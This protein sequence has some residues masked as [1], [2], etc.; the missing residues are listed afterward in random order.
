M[1]AES[2]TEIA[3]SIVAGVTG[4][5]LIISAPAFSVRGFARIKVCAI[6]TV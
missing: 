5:G 1:Y 6:S 4:I 2:A 3:A